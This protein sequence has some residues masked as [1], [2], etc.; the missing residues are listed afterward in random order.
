MKSFALLREAML[1]CFNF[2]SLNSA[3]NT[4]LQ[5]ANLE[6]SND[7][8]II[9][10]NNTPKQ[11][12]VSDHDLTFSS[13]SISSKSKLLNMRTWSETQSGKGKG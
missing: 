10:A 2:E 8:N 11:V 12:G 4:L 1:I 6:S 5:A 3:N 7:T 9:S 13:K